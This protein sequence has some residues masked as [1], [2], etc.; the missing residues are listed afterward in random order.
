MERPSTIVASIQLPTAE[1]GPIRMEMA[2]DD[3]GL[4]ADR[5]LVDDSGIDL[6]ARSI[7]RPDRTS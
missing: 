3:R 6:P 1:D 4:A 7:S 5:P 2:T